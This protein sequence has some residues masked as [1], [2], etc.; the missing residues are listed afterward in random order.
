MTCHGG[1]SLDEAT[2]RTW[3]NPEAI[4]QESGLHAGMVFMDIG[5]GEGFFTLLAAQTVGKNGLVYAV[6]TDSD[7]IE[8]LKARAEEKNLKNIRTKVGAGEETIFCTACANVIFYSM[9]LHDFNDPLQVLLNAKKMLKPSGI[10]IDLDWKKKPMQSGPPERIRYSE[11]DASELMSQAGFKI[12]KIKDAGPYHY[13]V[14]AK[15]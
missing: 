6:D 15:S 14:T 13:I 5:C 4:L 8:R 11:E 1:F 2:R 12:E 7:A 9:V 10:V 3:Y